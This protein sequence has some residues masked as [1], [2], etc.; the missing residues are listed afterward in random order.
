MIVRRAVLSFLYRHDTSLTSAAQIARLLGHDRA[1]VSAALETLESTG[2][3]ERSRGSQGV[4]LHRISVPEDP[5][6]Y[7]CFIELMKLDKKREG[8]LLLLKHLPRGS[9]RPLI[10]TRGLR[11]A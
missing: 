2:L 10:R 7:S 6:Q 11:L 8:R 1:T 4:R 3:I 5:L 9:M